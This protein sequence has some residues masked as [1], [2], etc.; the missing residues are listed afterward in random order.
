M[1]HRSKRFIADGAVVGPPDAVR[2]GADVR[3]QLIT[4]KRRTGVMNW[5]VLCRWALCRSLAEPTAPTAAS[6]SSDTAVEMTWKTFAG[7][8]GDLYWWLIK[9]RTQQLQLSLDEPSLHVQLRAHITRGTQYL[10]GDAGMRD[11][12]DLIALVR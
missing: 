1:T 8:T 2:I 12:P 7:N 3:E 9:L 10:V 5:N 6:L 11:T 4:M